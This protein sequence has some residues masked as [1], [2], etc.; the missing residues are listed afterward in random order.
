VAQHLLTAADR[1]VRVRLLLDHLK[2]SPEE[3]ALF[4][5]LD[6]HERIEVRFFNPFSSR[7]PGPLSMVTEMVMDGRRLNRR[8]H[9]KLLVAD[10]V[11]AVLGGRNIGG[12]YFDASSDLRFRDLDVVAIGAVVPAASQSFDQYWNS[13]F[14]YPMAAFKTRRVGADEL[15][16][17]RKAL[18]DDVRAFEQSDYAEAVMEDLPE[19]PSAARRGEW[20]WGSA[21]LVAD[22]P[23]K[24]EA[25]PEG[26][27]SR[28]L[29][30]GPRLKAL[31]DEASS[32]LKL[33]SPY[34]VPGDTGTAFLAGLERRGVQ[35]KV[36]TNSLASTDEPMVHAAYV[37]YRRDL[38]VGGVQIYELKPDAKAAQESTAKAS[39]SGISL[40]AKAF[41][42]DGRYVFI[43]SLNLDPRSRLLNTEMGV[44]VDSP[45]LAAAVTQYFD[46]AALPANAYE[47]A[48]DPPT[49]Q[50]T[51]IWRA[52]NDQGEER[53]TIEPQASPKRRVQVMVMRLFPIDGLL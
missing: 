30:I 38:V 34:F 24:V 22:K 26:E 9:N 46:T 42:V 44:I 48:L 35:V 41:E 29:R 27:R 17:A 28:T 31:M 39:S 21:E 49:P 8:M 2:V 14:A 16:Q 50:G 36:L 5:V 37:H 45:E 12:E 18:K 19:G 25:D 51:L 23:E 20:F 47:V 13:E 6:A 4:E 7:S 52:S 32:E 33:I 40:H 15:A 1:G 53:H 10:N 43:G 11:V 3:A